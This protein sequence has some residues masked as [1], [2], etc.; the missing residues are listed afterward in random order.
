MYTKRCGPL[1]EKGGKQHIINLR[2]ARPTLAKHPGS[3]LGAPSM[4]RAPD[5]RDLPNRYDIC[6]VRYPMSEDSTRKMLNP[7]HGQ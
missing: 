7:C 2:L 3:G 5:A 6:N 1:V 4:K